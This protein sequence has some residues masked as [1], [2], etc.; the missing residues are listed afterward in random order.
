MNV[1]LVYPRYPDTFWS[2]SHAL[3]F[4]G[5]KASYPPM[6]LL[7]VAA[8]LPK[9]WKLKLI[10]M[11]VSL[12]KDDDIL[13]ADY[14]FISAMAIQKSSVENILARCL[15]FDRK[16][17][18]GGPLFSAEQ[19]QFPD[20]SH[21]VLNEAETTLPHLLHDL[22]YGCSE[23]VYRSSQWA[24]MTTT[25]VPLWDLI[26]FKDY[27]TMSIQYSR[28]CPYDCEFCDI[29]VL[30]GHVP[31]AKPV[32]N[33]LRE[34]NALYQRGWRGSV[35]FVD[36]NFIGNKKRVKHEL[37]PA[38]I[39]WMKQRKYP[40]S[41]NTQASINLANDDSLVHLMVEAGFS[42]VFV[43]IETPDEKS[44]IE[45]G[46]LHNTRINLLDNVKKLQSSG[47]QVQGGFIVGFDSDKKDIFTRISQFINE[48][49]IVTSMVG[50]LNALP[51]TRLYKRL[52]RENRIIKEGTGNNTDFS[53][54]F[55]PKMDFKELIDGYK[56]LLRDIYKPEAYYDR[57]RTFL[58]NY[59]F[60]QK[61]NKERI[62][63]MHLR[64]LIM[65]TC[66]LGFKRGIRKHFWKL[67]M[68]TLVRRPKLLP[69]A[70][71]LAIYGEHF[72]KYFEIA[73]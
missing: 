20:V 65:S 38:V 23:S 44:L 49:G 21:L 68:W 55:L 12:L 66:K 9:E 17:V 29:T 25:P 34:L 62:S 30:C 50:L 13:W 35:F 40:F 28:G 64:A 39:Q 70:V 4:I 48:S 36:D 2:F 14:V 26:N 47:L 46:K 51:N 60:E 7:T 63:I 52:L 42:S 33:I 5:K 59:K 8:M 27:A 6:G 53:M 71:T 1:L 67:M 11:N 54:N 58:R 41:F 24:D 19:G 18:A 10:D 16:V 32:D 15:K 57:V 73:V 31:R 69:L 37:L 61:F 3:R 72:M 22:K 45:C 43:G 56:K